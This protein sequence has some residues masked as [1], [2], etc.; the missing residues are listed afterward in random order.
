LTGSA[1]RPRLLSRAAARLLCAAFC[2][3][4]LSGACAVEK[5]A[6]SQ[7]STEEQL[8]H[9]S[10]QDL[11]NVEVTSVS[12]TAEPLSRAPAAVY[13]ITHDEIVRSGATSVPEALRLAPN[14]QV[15]QLTSTSWS[16][17]ARGFGGNQ[18][19]QNF[20]NKLL[21]L[22]DGRSVYNPLFSG[23]YWDAQT[24]LL[25][26]VDRIEIISGPGATLWGANAMNG[27][28]NII[29]RPAYLTQGTF[30][31]ADGG[32]Q[33]Q[34]ANV[35]YGGKIN[36]ETAYRLYG[37]AFRRDALELPDA[38]SARD[39]WW[40]GQAGFR[41][42]SSLADD[43]LTLQGDAYHSIE[44]VPGAA[45]QLV[46]G[47]NLLGRWQHHTA[48]SDLQLQGYFDDTQRGTPNGGA[49]FVLHTYD[50]ELQ[51]SLEAG[52]ANR[53]VW[54][55]GER[56]NIYELRTVPGPAT[57]LLFA[58]THRSLT[59][60][61]VFAQDTWSIVPALS[62]TGG[63]KLEDD[64]FSGWAFQ[65]DARL[66]WMASDTMQ[67]W[68]AVSRAIR[69][70]TPFDEDVQEKVGPVLFLTGN[71]DFKPE[72]VT[73]YEIGYRGQPARILSL[74][75]SVYYNH[76]DDLRT[77]NV[78]PAFGPAAPFGLPLSWGNDM[79]GHT[80]GV[81]AW[82]DV[83]IT[84]WWRLSPGFRSFHEDLR[85]KS[86]YVP[87]VAISQAGDDPSAQGFL[88]SSMDLGSRITFDA[89]LRYVNALPDPTL[90]GYYEM[91][92]RVGWRV[93]R[94]LEL[95]L[96]GENLLHARHLEYPTAG[97]EAIPRSG[98]LEVRWGF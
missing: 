33:D 16:I 64:P 63:I 88:T 47:A 61:N 19:D 7:G 51:Q 35:R 36:E 95:A 69:A 15:R 72:R 81:E 41:I 94:K 14:L 37:L 11:T 82:A 20:S 24:V 83:Q 23:V 58:P 45:G 31:S 85:F 29:T 91:S 13:V 21:V 71:R 76:Y 10:L 68:A 5:A 52:A 56:L 4:V 8:A 78:G 79:E 48:R 34:D 53:L 96:S 59:L 38:A 50:L 89:S 12:K 92:A 54:G 80:Y 75:A 55:A 39:P 62:L 90:P 73:A 17:T 70:P 22:I 27:V 46:A 2:G 44:D 3:L 84:G 93:S 28:I 30:A 42:D 32:N 6:A 43:G 66:S 25:Q 67:F 87:I 9:M 74:S 57:S 60:G 97:G 98:M 40:K 77:I 86:G 49:G 1:A 26:D 65:P 18:A